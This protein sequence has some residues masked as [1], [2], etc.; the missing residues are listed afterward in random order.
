M[1]RPETRAILPGPEKG[2][3][4]KSQD[5][6]DTYRRKATI[7]Y[8]NRFRFHD[9]SQLILM[10]GPSRRTVKSPMKTHDMSNYCCP[11]GNPYTGLLFYF[12]ASRPSCDNTGNYP[13]CRAGILHLLEWNQRAVPKIHLVSI[14]CS[15]GTGRYPTTIKHTSRLVRRQ[16]ISSENPCNTTSTEKNHLT[17]P[18]QRPTLVHSK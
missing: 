4:H 16:I 7:Q 14:T 18:H 12:R 13:N 15:S 6:F 8:G 5:F 17:V 2:A 11:T 10:T 9:R 1:T 3:S